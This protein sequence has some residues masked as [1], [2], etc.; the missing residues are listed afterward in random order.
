MFILQRGSFKMI[1]LN[2][3]ET[4]IIK[5]NLNKI[6]KILMFGSNTQRVLALKYVITIA[7]IINRNDVVDEVYTMMWDTYNN[8]TDKYKEEE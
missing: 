3:K 2:S 8:N 5:D 4:E 7:E 6:S 1:S